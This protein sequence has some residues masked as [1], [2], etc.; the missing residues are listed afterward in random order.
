MTD[1]NIVS[2]TEG[3]T[4]YEQNP[5]AYSE[6][7]PKGTKLCPIYMWFEESGETEIRDLYG[8]LGITSIN[9]EQTIETKIGTIYWWSE[10]NDVYLN[11][12]SSKMFALLPYLSD[13]SGLQSLKTKY[14]TDINSMFFNS[15]NQS[16]TK[17]DEL[18]NWDTSKITNMSHL[19]ENCL[20]LTDISGLKNWNT[21]SVT[22]M[23]FLFADT[24]S[25]AFMQLSNISPLLNWD[26]SKVQ[27]MESMF[28]GCKMESLLALS[29]WDVS[30]V[31]NMS[32]MFR[33]CKKLSDA[34]AINNWNI[35]NV[36]NF[37]RM[38]YQSLSYPNFN[39][40]KGTWDDTGTFVPNN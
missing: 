40:I 10:S 14:V 9:N 5:N 25:G 39:K 6:I 12:D 34:S 29:D 24:D 26:V 1:D 15:A 22:D 33:G 23:S 19:F 30:N 18:S 36:T 28:L 21:S 38:F 37:D 2:W 35:T 31:K 8:N 4:A 17:V 11:P 13:I 3:Y 27:N 32:L 16:L 7:I 20:M